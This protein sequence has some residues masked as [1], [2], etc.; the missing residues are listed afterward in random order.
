MEPIDTNTIGIDEVGRG[1]WAG[2][3]VVAAVYFPAIP[4]IPENILIRDS[5]KL[6]PQQREDSSRFI[7]EKA[8]TVIESAPHSLIDTIGIQAANKKLFE[9]AAKKILN[10]ICTRY[11]RNCVRLKIDGRRICDFSVTHEFVIKGD[12]RLEVIAAASIVAKVWRDHLMVRMAKKYPVYGFEQHKGYG[13]KQHSSALNKYGLCAIHR[14]SFSP[15]KEMLLS[16]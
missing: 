2:P 12:A 7:L 4:R 15:M 5:K 8:I 11:P 13:T 16:L 6:R 1:A 10:T 9:S 3:L 14:R